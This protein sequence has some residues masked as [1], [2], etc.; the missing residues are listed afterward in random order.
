MFVPTRPGI[1]SEPGNGMSVRR[2]SCAW[3]TLRCSELPVIAVWNLPPDSGGAS[4][5]P[6]KTS[7]VGS[8]PEAGCPP[9]LPMNHGQMAWRLGRQAGVARS[10]IAVTV[11]GA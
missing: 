10:R 7:V 3:S 1:R 8:F 6:A 2:S 4:I 11:A 9:P 5:V